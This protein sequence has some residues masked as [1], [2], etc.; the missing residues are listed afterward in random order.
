[1]ASTT[2]VSDGPPLRELLWK[3]LT[4]TPLGWTS[5]T[6]ICGLLLHIDSA[7]VWVAVVVFALVGWRLAASVSAV[8]LPGKLARALLAFALVGAVFARFH[9]LNG[10][11]AGTLLLLLMCALKLLET[12]A[13]RDQYVVVGGTLFVLLAACLERQSLV[14]VPFYLLEAWLCCAALAIIGYASDGGG[15]GTDGRRGFDNRAAFLLAGRALLYSLPLAIVLFVVFP[16]LPGAFWALPSN[17]AAETGLSDTMSPGSISQLTSSYDIAFRVKFQG[18]VP[19]PNERYWRGPVLHNFDGYTWSRGPGDMYRTERL[20]YVG[21]AYHYRVSLEPSQQRWWLSLDTVTSSPDRKVFFT[22]DYELI[23]SDPVTSLTTYDAVSHTATRATQPLSPYGRRI[24]TAL[25]RG[26]NLRSMQLAKDMRARAGSDSA[27]VVSVLELLRT[28]GFV[29][30]LTPPVLSYDSVDDF[31]FNTRSGF[32]GHYASAFVTLARSAGIPARVVTGYLG[33]EWNP[34]GEY[35]I[36]RQSDAHSWAE[37]WLEGRGWTRVDP[38]AVV[39][40]ERLTRGVW[41]LLPGARSTEARLVHSSP[42][43]ADLLQRWDALNAW[44]NDHVLKFDYRAQLSLLSRLGFRSP[45]ATILGWAFAGVL[46]LWLG[47]IAWQ[48]GR[49]PAQRRPDRLA[50][51]YARLCGK[52]ARVGVP[53][54]AHQGPL[55]YADTVGEQRPDLAQSVRTLLTRYADLRYGAPREDARGDDTRAQEV[56][57]FERDVARLSVAK[58]P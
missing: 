27:F 57:G 32:C 39:A 31:L 40:P 24:E 43:L 36:V 12:R 54:S 15:V 51:A 50:R 6:L 34:I 18:A 46:T 10:L 4:S 55:A 49:G 42:A 7:P 1:M 22:Y 16:R 23:A 3:E 45:D 26:R 2:L 41:D 37:V 44:W 58:A 33:G 52:L 11:I 53:R 35:F 20:E 17:E 9:T 47:W 5:L 30:S 21:P 8:P 48:F 28:G 19:P 14:R 13:R 25:P 38:T 29:Y 56:A